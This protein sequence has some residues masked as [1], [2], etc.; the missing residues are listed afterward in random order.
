MTRTESLREAYRLLE[1]HFGPTGW[2][3]GETP[4]EIAVGAILTQN[5]AWTNVERAI[6]N[7]REA[8]SLSPQAI[9][10]AADESLHGL[11]RPAGYFRVKARRLRAFCAFLIEEHGG[12]MARLAELP[13]DELRAELL[14]VNGI[15]PETAD[16]IILYACEQPIFVVDAYTRRIAARHGWCTPD[17]SYHDLQGLFAGAIPEDLDVY[18]E[19]HAFIVYAGKHFCRRTPKCGECPLGALLPKRGPRLEA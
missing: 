8:D 17:A 6:A 3:P 7:L 14:A 4:F 5:T 13:R 16:D 11:L 15:G 1:A 18:K 12:A 10:D 19:Y 9:L 2:W